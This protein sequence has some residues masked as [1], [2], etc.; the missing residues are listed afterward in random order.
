MEQTYPDSVAFSGNMHI[1]FGPSYYSVDMLLYDL[2]VHPVHNPVPTIAGE[3]APVLSTE[4]KGL[5]SRAVKL[6]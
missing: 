5:T 1:P 3:H 2:L 6:T 4:P